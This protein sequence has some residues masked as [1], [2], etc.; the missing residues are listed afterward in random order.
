MLNVKTNAAQK[1]A[2]F[3]S[4][5]ASGRL[6]QMPGAY[7]PLV[8]R[9]IEQLGFDGIYISGA[10]LAADLGL[11]DIGLTTMS[12]VLQRGYQIQR[13]TNLPTLIDVD[14]GFGEPMSMAR[15]IMEL[16]HLGLS[17]CHL[18]D[19]INPKRCGHLDGKQVV[20]TNTMVKRIRAAVDARQDSNF[21]IMARTDAK[22]VEGL[23]SAIERAQAYV[24]A[25]A[26]AIFPE[27]LH[28]P[29]D[30]SAF[31][32]AIKV[33]LLANMTEFGKSPLLTKTE[34]GNLGFNLVIYPVS[35]LRVAMKASETLLKEIQQQGSQAGQVASMQT[36]A[37]LYDLLG[38]ADFNQFDQS[39]FNFRLET[40][41]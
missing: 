32:N 5:L 18:E 24:D 9:Q 16:E 27:A 39:I 11:P 6:L 8:A 25:G 31:R 30:F 13:S 4:D 15:T 34:L 26:D 10:A 23:A 7:S 28:T 20:D 3:R 41:S 37:E 12:E 1:R 33:P 19:Q 35:T 40:S 29:E 14:T 22:A 36:R 17:G 2:A 21:L 38:Y